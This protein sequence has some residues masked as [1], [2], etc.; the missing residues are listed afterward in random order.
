MNE[1][2]TYKL[3]FAKNE[4]VTCDLMLTKVEF[5]GRYTYEKDKRQLIYA[6]VKAESEEEALKMGKEIISDFKKKTYGED[7]ISFL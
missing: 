1:M 6:I 5:N 4:I 2:N 3:I 7:F